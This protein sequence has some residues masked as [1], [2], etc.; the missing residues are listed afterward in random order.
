[1]VDMHFLDAVKLRDLLEGEEWKKILKEEIESSYSNGIEKFLNSEYSL[2]KKI[3]PPK[4]QIF[5]VFN[6]IPP[7]EVEIL[8]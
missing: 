2:G 4:E 3:F 7:G 1:M 8:K 6:L 5:N